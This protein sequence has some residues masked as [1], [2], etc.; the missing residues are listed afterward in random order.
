MTNYPA[1]VQTAYSRLFIRQ[2]D[3]AAE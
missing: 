1:A 2:P 3:P